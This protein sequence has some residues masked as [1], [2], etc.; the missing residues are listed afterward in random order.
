MSLLSVVVVGAVVGVLGGCV[1]IDFSP[2]DPK[3]YSGR[4]LQVFARNGEF[5]VQQN[6]DNE[7]KCANAAKT[8]SSL[9]SLGASNVFCIKSGNPN[10]TYLASYLREVKGKPDS[11]VEMEFIGL[12]ACTKQMVDLVK[13]DQNSAWWSE[14]TN[15]PK[16]T[17]FCQKK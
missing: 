12:D 5:Q 14:G 3:T 15:V 17:K 10:T 7:A 9:G 13:V 2:A 16:I 8:I 11:E 1:S 6:M 4:Y